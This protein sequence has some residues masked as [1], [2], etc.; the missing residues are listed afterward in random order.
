[1]SRLEEESPIPEVPVVS[2]IVPTYC[3]EET[4][5]DCLRS[6]QNQDF[7]RGGIEII[8]VDSNSPDSTRRIAGKYADE[9]LNLTTRGVGKARNHGAKIARGEK[10]LFLDA[11]TL[12]EPRFIDEVYDAFANSKVVC[13]SGTVSGLER[14]S[15]G[16]SVFASIHYGFMNKLSSLTASLGF[17]LFP[18]VC[19]ACRKSV[20]EQVG[21]FDEDLAVGEDV[22]FSRKMGKIGRCVVR[23]QAKAYTSVRR[24]KKLGRLKTYSMYFGNYFKVFILNQRPWVQDFPNVQ[25]I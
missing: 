4:I 12:L 25:E 3:E 22:A 8:V 15:L 9:V 21:G 19:C 23:N 17:P 1:M 5:E 13:V 7:D 18:A 10:L 16:D 2:V 20:F 24:I 6:V 14:M 11:D